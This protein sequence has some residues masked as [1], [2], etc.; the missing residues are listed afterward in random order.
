MFETTGGSSPRLR[1]EGITDV[2]QTEHLQ[3][4]N[5]KTS[6]M[7]NRCQ[8]YTQV[9]ILTDGDQNH[10]CRISHKA[11]RVKA[12]PQK[13]VVQSGSNADT[14]GTSCSPRGLNTTHD[15]QTTTQSAKQQHKPSQASTRYL[16]DQTG[17]SANKNG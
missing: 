6:R 16:L 3:D 9:K 11:S 2:S 12:R 15:R 17:D 13:L 7:S 14:W 5:W 4:Y 10:N 8:N 1:L